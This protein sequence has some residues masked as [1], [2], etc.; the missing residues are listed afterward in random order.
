MEKILNF[1]INIQ[2]LKKKKRKGWLVHR[3]K[4]SESTASHIF[5][6]TI[7]S[8]ILAKE[9]GLNIEKVLKMALTHDLCEVFTFD[10]TPYDPLLSKKNGSPQNQKR[11]TEILKKWPKFTLEQKREKVRQKFEREHQACKKLLTDLPADKRKKIE[12]L[13]LDFEKGRSKEARFVKQADKAENFLQGME[14]WEKYGK[15]QRDLWIRW[16]REIFDDPVLIEF[17]KAIEK[18][19]C[20]KSKTEPKEKMGKILDFFIQIGKLKTISRKGPVLIGIKNPE[21]IAEHTFRVAIMAW[22]LGEE[23]KVNF[24]IERI[25][26]MALIHDI[27]EVYVGDITPYDGILPKSKKDWPELFDKWPRF[28]KTEKRRR[29][30]E[31]QKREKESLGK[32]TANLPGDL[33]DEL[34]GLWLDYRRGS[35]KEA[36]FV[37]QVNRMETLL[38]ALEY[39]KENKCRPFKSW[40]IGSKEQVDDSLLIKF[41]DELTKKFYKRKK[42]FNCE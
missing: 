6:M 3:I 31:K 39:G 11:I 13:W 22:I 4:D 15:I 38:Q 33:R 20:E 41:M 18:R 2:I 36:R 16:A 1:F 5:R 40:W 42:L 28:S 27:S 29:S 9:K 37:K 8:W 32:L 26:K 21:T 30:L 12:C 35:T 14:Y 19:F 25:L 24:K 10:E 23:K 34:K 7:M 17:E